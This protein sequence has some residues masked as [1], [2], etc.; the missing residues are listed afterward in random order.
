[1]GQMKLSVIIPCYNERDNIPLIVERM[2]VTFAGRDN[3][4]VILV[5]NGSTDGSDAVFAAQLAGQS[6]MR[7]VKVEQNQ[8][9][10]HGILF[11]L[12][13]ACDADVYAWTHADM[14]TDPRD[15]LTAFDLLCI[16]GVGSNIVKGKR[17]NR[18]LLDT[19]FT[20]MMQ[21]IANLALNVRVDDVNAQPKVFSKPFYDD[22]IR[23]QAPQDFS[24]DLFLL[25]Q[26]HKAGLEVLEVPV[27]F[28]DRM[29]GE[30]KG[31]GSWRTRIKLIKRTLAYIFKLRRT[32][33]D[34]ASA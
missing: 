15:V 23:G 19:A 14:Q 2:S 27:V 25:C 26:A 33:K 18:A 31:G 17:S 1:M 7:C 9:Y 29:H 4:E 21:M 3:V 28:A 5:D 30:A 32:L 22:Y 24:L 6:F 13:A 11:G 34:T 16:H 12:D 20:F 10:G 8:G